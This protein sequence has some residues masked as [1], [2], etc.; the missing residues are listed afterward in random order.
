MVIIQIMGTPQHWGLPGTA[1]DAVIH[2][3]CDVQTVMVSR[4]LL[5]RLQGELKFSQARIETLNFEVER[6]KSG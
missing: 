1:H 4:E 2:A 6:L 5:E 3:D